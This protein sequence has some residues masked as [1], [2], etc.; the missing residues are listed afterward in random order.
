MPR[1]LGM[2]AQRPRRR[3]LSQPAVE[4]HW[5]VLDEEDE[6]VALVEHAEP[7]E[8]LQKPCGFDGWGWF[9]TAGRQ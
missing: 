4:A 2:P 7:V 6:G 1:L 9:E 8:H 5:H 3:L